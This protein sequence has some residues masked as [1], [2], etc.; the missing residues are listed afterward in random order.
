M[1]KDAAPKVLLIQ[2]SL[3]ERVPDTA[4]EVIALDKDWSEIAEHSARNLDLRALGLRSDHLAYVIY[5]SGS[6]GEPK[7][8]MNEHRA[9]NNR[10]HWMQ[11]QYQLGENDRVLQKTPF[12]FDVSV[13]EFFWTLLNGAQLVVARPEGHKD[14]TYLQQ[15]IENAEITTLHFVPSML[16]IFLDQ[17][18][19]GRC[20]SLRHV[21]CSGEELSAS[22]QRKFFECLPEA[23]LSNLYGPT[24]AA[25]D[26]TAWECQVGD[27]SSRVPIGHPISNVQMY[28]LD[29]Y[30]KPVPIG[31]VGELY[32]G[33]VGVGRGY[34][35]RP[36]LTKQRFVPD[37]FSADPHAR[38]YKTGDLG[39]WRADGNI[40]YLGRNDHQV[41]I[42]GFRIE[43]GEIEAQL[44]QHPQ[45][46]EAVVIAREDIPGEKRLVAYVVSHPTGSETVTNVEALR[47]YLKEILPDYM[48]PSAFVMLESLPLTPN[49]KL[50]RRGLP[51]PELGAYVSRQY[52]AP[53]GEVEEH[54]ARIWQELL[55]VERVG[56]NDNF[57]ELGGHSLLIMQMLERLRRLA[58]STE[59]RR[60]F[61]SPTL[62]DLASALTN[63][64]VERFEIL[65]NLIPL[66]CEKITPEMLPLVEL[67][68][69][70]IERIERTVPGGAANI[71]DIYPLAPL[72]EGILFH[73]LLDERR[74]DIYVLSTILL[75]SSRDRLNELVVALQMAIDRHDVLRTAV[76]WEHLPGPVQVVY[77]QAILPVEEV[78]LDQNRDPTE[79]IREWTR[80]DRQAL[81]LRKAPLMRLTISE[82]RRNAQWYVLLQVHHIVCDHETAEVVTSE[83]VA[84]LQRCAPETLESVPY[85]NHVA[86]TLAYART[87]DAEGFF[88][89]KLG[90]I[91]E[92]TTPFALSNVHGDGT[93]V[94][95]A[96]EELDT[97]LAT[98]VRMQARRL[99]VSTATLFHAAWSLVVSRTSGRTDVVFGSVLLGR[100]QTSTGAQRALGIFINTLPLRIRLQNVSARELVEQTQRELVELL[101]HEQASLAMAQR[102][103]HIAGSAP[104]FSSL[105]NYR[106]SLPDPQ[107]QWS[108]A[109]GIQILAGQERT[110]YPITLS[111]DDVGE[112]FTLTAQTDQRVSAHRITGYMH[113]AMQ[114]LVEALEQS[115]LTLA[116]ALSILP[117]QERL[118]VIKAFNATNAAYPQ[119][120]LIH[121]LFEEQ[122]DRSPN[123][124]AVLCE[125]Q[126]YTYAE[127]NI[128]ANKL[129]WYLNRRGVGNGD[130]VP[131]LMPR[132]RQMLVAQLAVLKSG[133]V[134]V[135]VDP[136]LPVERQKFIIRDCGA[137]L[138]LVE[139][140]GG[141]LLDKI[142][143]QYINCTEEAL[144]LEEMPSENLGLQ[145]TPP[146]PAYVMYTSGSTGV[147]KGVIVPHR[148]VN[149][150]VINNNYAQIQP[151]D[152]VAHCSNPAFDASTFEVWGA[153]LNGAKV[154]IVPQKV[155]LEAASFADL[156]R[157]QHVTILWL[158]VGLLTQY[159]EALRTVFHRLRYLITGGDVVEPGLIRQV[160]RTS[161]PRY[162]LNA[163]GPTE[164]TTFSSTYLIEKVD[165]ET[166]SLP[167]GQPISNTQI[168]ILNRHL[169]PVPIGVAGE[170]YIG[171]AGVALGYLNRP[172]L[173]AERFIKDPF[174]ADPHARM[175]K[176]G[177]LGRW[178]ADGNIEYL[179]R[180]DHQVKIR[181]F[182]IELG[183][184]EAQ[185]VQHP[186]VKE[187]VVI[188][189]EDIPGEKRLVAYVVSHPTGS[190]TV[191]NVEALRVYLKEILPDY[192]VPSAFVMLESLPLTPNGKLDRRGLP[193]PEL[194]AY[195][196]RQYEAPEGEVEELVAEIWQTLLGIKRVGREDNFFEL[197]GHSLLATRVMVRLGSSLS[198]E[199][200]M[201]L[202]FEFPTLKALSAEIDSLRETR[203]LNDIAGGGSHTEEL[204]Q[205]LAS[206]PE[207]EVQEWMR[208]LRAG[209]P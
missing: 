161:P 12:S 54:L 31:V 84:C 59:V 63:G 11:S 204:L 10:L 205:R 157:Q 91:E 80:P 183:E 171:G 189:R 128:R 57:F 35:N 39:R 69:E 100:L 86:Q 173:T 21:V 15:I 112:G 197:G 51:A 155:V 18:Q 44:V 158:T 209:R 109:D 27:Q 90:D 104:L 167:I 107:S 143:A 159:I 75:V 177:D 71:Q 53:E 58:L 198:L 3:T 185:L 96:C 82:D 206:M 144:S 134:Y 99:A 175:Y 6:T 139:Q 28:V 135:P 83:V 187:A 181:G 170:V 37:P 123:A 13:W 160:I 20:S 61:E 146:P 33:G 26:V 34:M 148:A 66:A 117:E 106:H 168:Y 111:V 207:S 72:Q 115:P 142:P 110:N 29:R 94:D 8:A 186:Q 169:Q 43:L 165:D 14:P 200:P 62:S 208:N 23:K 122:V 78:T 98:R 129:A 5:T 68:A 145:G 151:S 127:I 182:R 141:E 178:R 188:A 76:L 17:H 40:E 85:R 152:C 81:E 24:E 194:G 166:K 52:E 30:G 138:I 162:L 50:D 22:L 47:V 192:M 174:S 4:A 180:N 176:T 2:D 93:R 140:S 64:E 16:Q 108:S 19:T 191:T 131:I 88:R 25:I 163:Y 1:L 92:P 196:S 9:L 113:K 190:E 137:R 95:E 65:P 133:G 74:G 153:L 132:S 156:L 38:M 126:L 97:A 201:R 118:Q 199:I 184:I 150:L 121:E 164:C 49:G 149:R 55:K 154:L 7:G 120:K 48:V 41:K 203:L 89:R 73:H 125:E 179:G 202:L 119:E 70:Q 193:A 87:H 116:V 101:S 136:K 105:L 103:S 147:P 36:E 114:S 124:V 172:E 42:R 77:R 32:I 130:Y 195:V 56:R 46:K 79:Q 60:I 102:C 67:N 45:V